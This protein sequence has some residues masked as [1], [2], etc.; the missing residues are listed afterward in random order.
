MTTMHGT[1]EWGSRPFALLE[2]QLGFET[3]N[4]RH[5]L[6]QLESSSLEYVPTEVII[7]DWRLC[8]IAIPRGRPCA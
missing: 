7:L 1:G 5:H 4:S 2:S 6:Q 3:V 8:P